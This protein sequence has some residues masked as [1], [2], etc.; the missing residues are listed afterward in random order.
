[1]K[2]HSQGPG[3]WPL[4]GPL[5]QLEILD[6]QLDG[7][8]SSIT[9]RD[10]ADILWIRIP[11][12]THTITARG[13][14]INQDV[15]QLSFGKE[16]G[17]VRIVAPSWQVDGIDRF[18]NTKGSIQ[19][20]RKQTTPRST[21]KSARIPTS[22]FLSDWFIASRNITLAVDWTISTVL[23]RKG[24]LRKPAS[25]RLPL[26]EGESII[27]EGVTVEN[28][29]VVA[30]FDRGAR[31][32]QFESNLKKRESLQLDAPQRNRLSEQ[33]TIS[34]SAIW[35]CNIDGI[36]P[37][38]V[39]DS[40][41]QSF[42]F[43]PF[44]GEKVSIAVSRPKGADGSSLTLDQSQLNW[45]PGSRMLEGTLNFS[46]RSTSSNAV[47]LVLPKD[48]KLGRVEID[49][50]EQFIGVQDQ[51]LRLPLTPGSHRATA[52]WQQPFDMSVFVTLPQ[53]AIDPAPANQNISVQVPASRW[54]I[55]T[56]GPNWGP[57]ILFWSKLC[58]IIIFAILLARIPEIPLRAVHWALLGLGLAS[59][60]IWFMIIPVSWF[61][62]NSWRKRST[63]NSRWAFN[64]VQ[65]L[66]VCV[67]F[68]SL[69]ILYL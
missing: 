48:A 41:R 21:E 60:E 36:A 66:L 14:F 56:G 31:F 4:P 7:K 46:A 49:G 55:A 8:P 52:T 61:L 27:S 2:I 62:L 15:I 58:V 68:L 28:G 37:T 40:T 20:V 53:I 9:R 1:M 11:E 33:W 51:T 17:H 32:F 47:K 34:C 50:Q 10:A 13:T 42:R 12:G 26:L 24:D 6:V 22:T 23:E 69:V 67:T 16:P 18:G 39:F 45:V 44:P 19:L 29:E 25:M 54:L 65:V 64:S 57:V 59:L 63:L 5:S 30:A 35:S 3:A 43:D 38:S